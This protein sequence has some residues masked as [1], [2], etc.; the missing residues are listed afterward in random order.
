MRFEKQ[1]KNET[2]TFSKVTGFEKGECREVEVCKPPVGPRP[3]RP[4]PCTKETRELCEKKP[5]VE[6]FTK[7]VEFCVPKPIRVSIM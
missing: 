6:E 1:C 5:V 4:E 7:D 3:S 2:R